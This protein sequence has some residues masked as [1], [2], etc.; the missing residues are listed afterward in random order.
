MPSSDAAA[1]AQGTQWCLWHVAQQ[2]ADRHTAVLAQAA[3]LLTVLLGNLNSGRQVDS[4]VC[5]SPTSAYLQQP[6]AG[7]IG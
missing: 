3:A 5:S 4:A 1:K 7:H 6:Q 2:P